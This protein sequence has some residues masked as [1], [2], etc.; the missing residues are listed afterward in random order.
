M[1]RRDPNAA[2]RHRDRRRA[3]ETGDARRQNRLQLA[4]FKGCPASEADGE[5][6]ASSATGGALRARAAGRD[7]LSAP[8][9]SGGALG[10]RAAEGDAPEAN[11][12]R[13]HAPMS[14]LVSV[15]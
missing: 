2:T 4:T 7:A 11:A 12:K 5:L 15:L 3:T 1:R 8:S 6:S 10:A 13:P 9:A 14:C